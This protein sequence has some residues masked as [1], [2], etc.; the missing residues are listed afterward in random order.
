M[1]KLIIKGDT[2][3]DMRPETYQLDKTMVI[4]IVNLHKWLGYERAVPD[5]PDLLLSYCKDWFD[6]VVVNNTSFPRD[7]P[8]AF[9]MRQWKLAVINNADYMPKPTIVS[10]AHSIA[11]FIRDTG[12]DRLRYLYLQQKPL[13]ERPKQLQ[14][15]NPLTLAEIEAKKQKTLE[16]IKQLEGENYM[17]SNL[18]KAAESLFKP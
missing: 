18:F 11:K 2:V 16:A 7:M 17:Q 13:S 1:T 4:S 5:K 14:A 8:I 12:L 6:S 3:L 15:S 10:F 9:V